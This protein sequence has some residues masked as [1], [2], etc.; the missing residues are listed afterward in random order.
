VITELIILFVISY[1]AA[2]VS[3]AAGFGG[4]LIILPFVINIVGLQTAVQF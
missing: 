3:G 2:T 1:I 4:A